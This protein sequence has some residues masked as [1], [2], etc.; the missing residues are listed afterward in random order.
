MARRDPITA[1]PATPPRYSLLTAVGA[2]GQTPGA[3]PWERGVTWQSEACGGGD[4][5][6]ATVAVQP[7]RDAGSRP[8][9]VIASPF[10][11]WAVDDASTT[12]ISQRDWQGRA[13]RRLEATQSFQIAR[14]VWTGALTIDTETDPAERNPYL[15]D[16]T[17]VVD[18]AYEAE[19]AL[20]VAEALAMSES[21]GRRIMLHVPIAVLEAALRPGG[22]YIA[23]DTGG[24]LTTPM[25]NIVVVDAGYPG[26][27]PDA[28]EGGT[29]TQW[30]YTSPMLG[31]R[32]S[33]VETLPGSLADAAGVAAALSR[34]AND[35]TVWAQRLALYQ[36]DP[37][38]RIAVSTNVPA[39]P[40]PTTLS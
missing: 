37:C 20:G 7:A 38:A 25:G 23:R 4:V 9:R 32:L 2:N 29:T 18:S 27:A 11:V 34:P 21:Q 16:T 8:P 30:I 17:R 24:V 5:L 39:L 10:Y 1:P 36:L 6:A 31:V 15:A 3:E 35:L 14:E 33:A 22:S 40:T 12:P 28:Y 19:R 13:R 26:T